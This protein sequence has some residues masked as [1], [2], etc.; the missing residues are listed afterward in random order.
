MLQNVPLNAS[1]TR[2]ARL[3][4]CFELWAMCCCN[5]NS[6]MPVGKW[7]SPVSAAALVGVAGGGLQPRRIALYI[8]VNSIPTNWEYFY[9]TV[10][11]SRALHV[12]Q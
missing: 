8:V 6:P 4:L 3:K 5:G 1:P 10:P 2:C 9:L 12:A 11:S 7:I